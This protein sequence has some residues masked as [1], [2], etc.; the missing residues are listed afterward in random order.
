MSRALIFV[1]G[2]IKDIESVR[3]LLLPYDVVIAADGGTR[4]ALSLDLM[5]SVIIG[6]LD[7]LSRDD[8]KRVEKAGVKKFESPVD[9]DETDFELALQYAVGA[10]HHRIL[11]IAALGGRFDQS[12]GNLSLLG[13]PALANLDVR[14]DDGVE[15]VLFIRKACRLR[16]KAGDLVSLIPWGG[17]AAGVV[18][19]GLRWPLQEE[20]LLAHRTRGISNEMLGETA[21]I[22]LR[23]GLLLVIHRRQKDEEVTR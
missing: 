10:G 13:D 11:V 16:G 4:H 8:R 23:S 21:S 19:D 20:E 3:Q 17:G 5:P 9:K 1:N 14:A 15:E 6:D 22:S 18:T 12:I 2:Q 7:S